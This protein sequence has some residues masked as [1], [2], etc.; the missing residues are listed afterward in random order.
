[1]HTHLEHTTLVGVTELRSK[2]PE[3]EKALKHS[4]VILEK[5]HKPFAVL[6]PMERYQKI[7]E[8]LELLEDRVLGQIAK[9]REQDISEKDYYSLDAVLKKFK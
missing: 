8:I 7:E 4:K 5:R 3:V 1:M 2:L 6:V 9:E